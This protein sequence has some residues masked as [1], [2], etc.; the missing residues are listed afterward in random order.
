MRISK[1]VPM[2]R[3]KNYSGTENILLQHTEMFV[4]VPVSRVSRSFSYGLEIFHPYA[5]QGEG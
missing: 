1:S 2:S 5:V 3:V 4:I